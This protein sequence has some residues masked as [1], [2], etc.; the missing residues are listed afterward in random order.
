M[1]RDKDERRPKYGVVMRG[2]DEVQ[3]NP[4]K[5]T[6]NS[7]MTVDS[8]LD[9]MKPPDLADV[10]TQASIE[11]GEDHIETQLKRQRQHLSE[12]PP[13]ADPVPFESIVTQVAQ[14]QVPTLASEAKVGQSE[15]MPPNELG[16]TLKTPYI[17]YP[18]QI[19]AVKW[20]LQKESQPYLGITGGLWNLE[21]GAG[22]SLC[23]MAL[24]ASDFKPGQSATLVIMPKTLLTN[25]LMDVAK[26]FGT[27]LKVIVWERSIMESNFYE[28]TPQTPFKN[29]LVLVS[30]DTVLG[31][32][33]STGELSKSKGGNAKLSRVAQ[34][35]FDT[36]WYRVVCD[37]SHRFSN[38]KTQLFESLMLLKPGRRLCLS[39]T[40][41]KNYECELFAQLVFC[42]L[43][44][45]P[46][47]RRWTVQS[48]ESLQLRQAVFCKSIEECNIQ[49]PER[50][51]NRQL[52]ELSNAEKQ[53]YNI[54]MSKSTA[55]MESFKAKKALFANVL[56]M[57]TRLRQACIAPH[58]L[59]PQSKTR[60][61][62]KSEEERLVEG[63]ILGPEN[64]AME[65]F[66]RAPLGASGHESAKMTEM[67]RIIRSIPLD[68]KVIV[69]SE[70]A[71]AV[72]L[73]A[74]VL[75]KSFGPGCAEMVDGDTD[76][77]D[78]SFT[79]FK[80]DPKVRFLCCTSVA[81]QGLTFIEANH[82]I[83]INP[84]FNDY[85]SKQTAGRICRIGQKKPCFIWSI[86]IRNSIES[87]L[88]QIC[89]T[90]HNIREILLN[91][92]VNSEV[93]AEFLGTRMEIDDNK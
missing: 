49:L 81:S 24:L 29:H 35:F 90:K 60:K 47:A 63:S 51:D 13:L 66:V 31:L 70:W 39:G 8:L 76:D 88:I 54:L 69:F 50:K 21:M 11:T 72:H 67:V 84:S 89:E 18:H 25:Y 23:T 73:C 85:S 12:P 91:Q 92:G 26:F 22:K 10:L 36:P 57:F 30:Y 68:D 9:L 37:E 74:T 46:D 52:V 55:M 48:Y 17:L 79:R 77:R 33:K 58:L 44:A 5:R 71:S 7:L 1:F 61:L 82:V 53:I 59:A 38:H 20:A 34:Y 3:W 64:I 28:F 19:D 86:I 78:E 27:K 45:L 62:T 16:V 6:Y 40:A 41:V 75:E 2:R 4:K 83:L 43:N 87:K 15:F 32:A 14:G 42:G 93:L 65:R 56:E 80:L